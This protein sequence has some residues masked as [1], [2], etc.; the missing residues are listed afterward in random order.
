MWRR[1]EGGYVDPPQS[2][3]RVSG[4]AGLCLAVAMREGG[5][6][7]ELG[8]QLRRAVA[9]IEV[10][11][12]YG[13]DLGF[14]LEQGRVVD[15][16]VQDFVSNLLQAVGIVMLVMLFSLGLRTGLVV[17]S[18]IPM[19]ILMAFL[20]MPFAGV[21]IDQMSLAAL[22]ISLG[23]L[24]DNAIVMS[25]NIMVQMAEGV[26]AKDA[27]ISSARELS[28]PLLVSSL[29]TA[30]AFLPIYLADSTVGEYTA[31]LFKVVS[32]TLLC[33]WL[34]AMTMIPLLCYLFLRVKKKKEE[35]GT[36]D[37]RFYRRYRESL[38][39]ALKRPAL[40]LLA[41]LAVFGGSLM[42]FR[43]VP[44]IFFP[45]NDRPTLTAE[46]SLPTGTPLKK[47]EAV[48][49]AAEELL[50]PLRV[51]PEEAAAGNEGV[52]DWVSY[53]GEGGPRFY[54]GFDPE[55][56]NSG[57][58]IMIINATSREF[59]DEVVERLRTFQDS[60]PGLRA[61]VEPLAAGPPGGKPISIR[62][63]GRDQDETFELVRQVKERLE[64]LEGPRNITDNWGA[65]SKKMVI[66]IDDDRAQESRGH[67]PGHRPVLGNRFFRIQN[68]GIS[69]RG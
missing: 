30:A 64:S 37:G 65:R 47:T 5:N 24:V 68:H 38:I 41:V 59:V 58:S 2:K 54:L 61:T 34:L 10:A 33:S 63:S 13:V 32:I 51:S 49:T 12:P 7:V 66:K 60:V 6:I 17:A 53:L 20:F 35:T 21:G 27:A 25:E 14:L 29:T 1:C 67:P 8:K 16:K 52:L 69:G 23:L 28:L 48:V 4:E 9:R 43:F 57:Y 46:W 42:L 22:I 40:S 50:E 19:A 36:F 44:V 56:S 45:D 11:Y 39:S 3:L 15:E 31:P 55:Q 18:L 26:P 62:I